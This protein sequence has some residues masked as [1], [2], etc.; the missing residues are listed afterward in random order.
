LSFG[1]NFATQR[2]I[3][4]RDEMVVVCPFNAEQRN[5]CSVGKLSIVL[6]DVHMFDVEN[7]LS[8]L[9]GAQ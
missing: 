2:I 8:A 4:E 1:S 6:L 9:Q 3:C 5:A 7:I